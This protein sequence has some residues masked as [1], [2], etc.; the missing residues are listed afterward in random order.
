MA[1]KRDYYEVLGVTKSST[2]D[3]IK[4]A[5]R[6][7][8]IKYHPDKN[9]GNAEAE[10]KFKEATEAY[11][12]LSDDSKKQAYDRF[13]FE[14]VNYTG[15]DHSRTYADFSDIFGNFGG[16]SDI[17]E[18]FFGGGGGFSGGSRR[19]SSNR[20]S[21]LR[22]NV[23]IPFKE[24]IF[25]TKIEVNY[26]KNCKCE[27]CGGSGAE[28]GSSKKTCPTCGGAG[29]VRRSQGFFSVSST[30]ST[31]Q[32]EGQVIEKP[33]SACLGRGTTKKNKKIKITIPAGVETGQSLQVSG[34]G[35]D[36]KDGGRSGD[37]YVLIKVKPHKYFERDNH[38]LYVL[39]PISMTQAALGS[40]IIINTLDEKKVKLK[41]PAGTQSNKM[42]KVKGQGAPYSLNSSGR[43]DLYVKILVETPEKLSKKEKDLLKK[44]AEI[45]GENSSP[46]PVKLSS[47]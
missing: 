29:Q 1:E 11:E 15:A 8:A 10:A 13:G 31:C 43:G 41:I 23:T 3:E 36:G 33:C 39:I 12:V 28:K 19:G 37:L 42:L 32:G 21:D 44:F 24:S 7:L 22:Y 30:C 27:K 17:F 20:G 14:G 26:S 35:D 18:S 45:K 25:G 34:Q 40:E 38:N 46:T 6:K 9:Q 47:L 16:F 4:K 2:K 5:Y